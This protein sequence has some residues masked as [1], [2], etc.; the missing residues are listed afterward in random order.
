M[1]KDNG[2]SKWKNAKLIKNNKKKKVLLVLILS[3]LVI[4]TII[5]FVGYDV[6]MFDKNKIIEFISGL[7]TLLLISIVIVSVIYKVPKYVPE[8]NNCGSKIKNL[9]NDCVVGKLEFIEAIEKVEYKNVKSKVKGNTTYYR[10]GYAINNQFGNERTSSSSYEINDEVPIIKKYYVYN[11]EYRCKHCN[12][13]Y[14]SKNEE[15]S[16]KI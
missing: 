16:E 2:F 6:P 1:G 3:I 4:A 11:V 8:C 13:L 10:G 15:Y 14:C 5:F 7:F 12:E 9:K